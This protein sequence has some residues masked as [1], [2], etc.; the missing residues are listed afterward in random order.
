MSSIGSIGNMGSGMAMMQG[1]QH[2]RPDPAQMAENLF[3][4]LDTASQGYL[5]K[6]D[7]QSAFDNLTTSETSATDVEAL[8]SRLDSDSDG[9]VTQQEFSDQLTKLAEQLDQQFQSMR[10]QGGMQAGGMGGMP[11]PPPPPEND[12]G[13]T[14]EELQNQLKEIGSTDSNRS[15]LIS[16]IVENFEAADT[17]GD[18][19][20]S[21]REAMAYDQTSKASDAGGAT[22]AAADSTTTTASSSSEAQLLLQIMRL[23][24]AY[25]VGG[26]NG[27]TTAS[28]LSAVA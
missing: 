7:F 1:M 18:G 21:F 28:A 6:A 5:Q 27:R 13:F 24:Q 12:A 15:S 3:A 14:Q 25:G 20:V 16:S 17:D 9:K 4:Q 10:M 8:F 11:P 22:T 19:K 23:M 26:E 2:R